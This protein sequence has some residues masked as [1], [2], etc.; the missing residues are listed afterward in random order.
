MSYERFAKE[1]SNN[2]LHNQEQSER[3]LKFFFEELSRSLATPFPV[4]FRGFGTFKRIEKP[5][6][7][8]RNVHTGKIEVSPSYKTVEFIPS[9]SLLNRL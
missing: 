1:I 2:F 7:R 5:P 6:R 3:L 9:E 4:T 8:Y